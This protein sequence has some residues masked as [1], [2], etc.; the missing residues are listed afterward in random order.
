MAVKAPTIDITYST[1]NRY[2]FNPKN[3][4]NERFDVVPAGHFER[5]RTWDAEGQYLVKYKKG[6][7]KEKIYSVKYASNTWVFTNMQTHN[8][9]KVHD[10]KGL[11]KPLSISYA[12]TVIGALANWGV[13]LLLAYAGKQISNSRHCS[14][15]DR[16]ISLPIV[17][18][19]SLLF[20]IFYTGVVRQRAARHLA[21]NIVRIFRNKFN[22]NYSIEKKWEFPGMDQFEISHPFLESNAFDPPEATQ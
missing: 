9:T 2:V 18:A 15:L 13:P 10:P 1:L 20:A 21:E 19:V 8:E 4:S 16:K 7:E 5:G 6:D 17:G 3:P 22:S 12:Y 14:M 11:T